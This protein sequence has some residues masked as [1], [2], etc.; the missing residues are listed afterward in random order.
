M[1]EL[2]SAVGR[3]RR[4]RRRPPGRDRPEQ[5]LA[6]LQLWLLYGIRIRRTPKSARIFRTFQIVSSV[7]RFAAGNAGFSRSCVNT[8]DRH[9][10][11]TLQT[12]IFNWLTGE[13][14]TSGLRF[15]DRFSRN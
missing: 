12:Q 2:C 1:E 11:D 8:E 15:S 7:C 6:G 5:D 3:D 14:A 9:T 13:W 10:G 4:G